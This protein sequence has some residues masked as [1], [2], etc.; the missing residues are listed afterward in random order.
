MAHDYSINQS[1]IP[2]FI[3]FIVVVY[4]IVSDLHSYFLSLSIL[5]FRLGK[6]ETAVINVLFFHSMV[7]LI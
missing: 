3:I 1:G 4:L 6:K 7:I 2:N 5:F